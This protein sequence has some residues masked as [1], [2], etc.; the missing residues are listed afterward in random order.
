MRISNKSKQ[1]KR[2]G[3]A[4][5][6]KKVCL[7]IMIGFL[8]GAIAPHAGATEVYFL[9]SPDGSIKVSIHMPAPGSVERPHWSAS[10]RN[11]PILTE[12]GL[13]LQTSDGGEL[14]AGARV[15]RQRR[16]SVNERVPVRFGKSDHANNRFQESRYTLE[17]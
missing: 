4:R 13:G 12:C 5:P 6:R 7:S 3:G 1:R 10:F 2:R 16:R 15:L 8:L 14:M 17:T 11:K 9:T